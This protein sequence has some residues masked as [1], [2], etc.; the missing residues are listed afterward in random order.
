MCE[1]ILMALL[2]TRIIIWCQNQ[3]EMYTD[4]MKNWLN[5]IWDRIPSSL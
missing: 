2:L 3:G 5:A 4:F 1:G